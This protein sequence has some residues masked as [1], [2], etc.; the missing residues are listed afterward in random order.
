MKTP[1]F[2]FHGMGGSPADWDFVQNELPG[3]AL[4]LPKKIESFES[5]V[6]HFVTEIGRRSFADAYFL[7]GYSMGGRLAVSVAHH[8]TALGHPPKALALV[9]TGLGELDPTLRETRQRADEV[10]ANLAQENPEGFWEKWYLQELFASF[11]ALSNPRKK[12]WLLDRNSMDFQHLS[13]QLRLLGPSMHPYLLPSVQQLV[14][15]GVSVVY[16]VGEQDKKYVNLSEALKDV[17]PV[18]RVPNAGHI[19]PLEAPEALGAALKSFFQ[20]FDFDLD[21]GAKDGR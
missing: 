6:A 13:Q 9:S 20:R 16:L 2:Y 4:A 12:K 18:V 17:A 19:L 15:L 14:S 1:L 3:H 10:W 7:C 11:R 21:E 8:L 5:T